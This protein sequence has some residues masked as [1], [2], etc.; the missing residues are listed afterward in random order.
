MLQFLPL[1]IVL[2]AILGAQVP[3]KPLVA[4]SASATE[5][6]QPS[7]VAFTTANETSNVVA[8]PNAKTAVLIASSSNGREEAERVGVGMWLAIAA[9]GGTAAAVILSNRKANDPFQSSFKH[10]ENTIRV[11]QASPKLQ[12]QLLRLLH[13]DRDTASRLLAQVKL[14]HPNQSA[15]WAAEKVI[16]DLE[17]DRH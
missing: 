15:N 13:N 17:R 9:A 7:P 8:E 1:S 14:H 6:T 2:V 16:Y 3:D 10:Q 4:S 12:K 5:S 11:D